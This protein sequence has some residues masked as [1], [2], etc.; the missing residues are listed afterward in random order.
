MV[1]LFARLG[2]TPLPQDSV[3]KVMANVGA[4]LMF[5]G[6]YRLTKRRLNLDPDKQGSSFYDWYLLTM[7]WIVASTGMGAQILR[8]LDIAVL[9]YP[10][11]FVHLV[12]VFMLIA[13]LPWSKLGHLVYRTVALSYAKTTGRIPMGAAK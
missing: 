8:L 10:V 6:L 11:Y 12:A 13:Y 5:F 4:L 3:I 9:A 2:S 7:I 1:N